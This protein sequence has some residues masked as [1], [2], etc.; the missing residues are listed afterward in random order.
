MLILQRQLHSQKGHSA[1][2]SLASLKRI[3]LHP[4]PETG[5]RPSGAKSDLPGPIFILIL[6]MVGLRGA[7][8][9]PLAAHPFQGSSEDGIS[10]DGSK[11][12]VVCNRLVRETMEVDEPLVGCPGERGATLGTGPASIGFLHP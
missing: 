8:A 12:F 5:R 10:I 1:R 2:R 7:P 6:E 4:H 3:F 11:W 9:E